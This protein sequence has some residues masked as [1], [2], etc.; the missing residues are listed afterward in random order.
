MLPE[1]IAETS[2]FWEP[3]GR[4]EAVGKALRRYAAF[5]KDWAHANVLGKH[6][7]TLKV[8]PECM[9]LRGKRRARIKVPVTFLA[10]IEVLGSRPVHIRESVEHTSRGWQCAGHILR[11]WDSATHVSSYLERP[12]RKWEI[13]QHMTWGWESA[14]QSCMY[15]E[16][17]GGI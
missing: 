4:Y 12:E 2:S 1:S 10:H 9:K 7:V 6:G 5:G 17:A 15:L 16:G 13:P 11:C 8:P 14:A 3:L